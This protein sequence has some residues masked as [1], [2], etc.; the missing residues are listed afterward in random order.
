[1]PFTPAH[2]AAALPFRRTRLIPS[3]LVI[4]TLAPDFEYFIRFKLGSAFGHTVRGALLFA[5]PVA[6]VVLWLFHRYVKVPL[7]SVLPNSLESRLIPYLERFRFFGLSRF[8]LIVFSILLGIATHIVWD[9]FT[10]QRMWLYGHWSFLRQSS[11]IPFLGPIRNCTLLQHSSTILG[12]GFLTLWVLHW[13]RTA[14][15]SDRP[16]GRPISTK[17]KIAAVTLISG[18]AV[19]AGMSRG[20][21]AA[22]VPDSRNALK[23][24]AGEAVVTVIPLVWWQLLLIGLVLRRSF[25][26]RPQLRTGA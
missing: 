7:V 8:L 12:M 19:I 21:A 1:V 14:A 16:S 15:P 5:L 18:V 20:L 22:G 23:L 6:L 9:S 25:F 4:G 24:F 10:H 26:S 11:T 13:Y 2:A 17:W 3:A